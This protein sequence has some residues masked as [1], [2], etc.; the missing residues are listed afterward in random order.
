MRRMLDGA[1]AVLLATACGCHR[2]DVAEEGR[3]GRQPGPPVPLHSI[4]LHDVQGLFGGRRLWAADDRTAIVQVVGRP[5][6]G[7]SGLWEKRYQFKLSEGEWA[8]VERLVGAHPQHPPKVPQ[9]PG[10]P[11]EARPAIMVV[12]KAGLIQKAHEWAGDKDADFD[13]LYDYLLGLCR[14]DGE[15]VREGTYDWAWRPEGFGQPW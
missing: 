6:A 10:V 3:R 7:H 13:P 9:R 1:A 8:E 2:G 15:P 12:T 5:P 11:D 4:V 14:T